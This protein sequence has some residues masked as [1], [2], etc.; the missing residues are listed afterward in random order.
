M[1]KR[2][3]GGGWVADRLP[4]IAGNQATSSA[5]FSGGCSARSRHT[6]GLALGTQVAPKCDDY[7]VCYSPRSI[8]KGAE[9]YQH[10]FIYKGSQMIGT[11]LLL[12][13]MC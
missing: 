1:W 4:S 12:L 5:A 6:P 2:V 13:T 3:W 9:D 11:T 7:R 8:Y 10:D